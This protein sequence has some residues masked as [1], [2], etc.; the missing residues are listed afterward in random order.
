MKKKNKILMYKKECIFLIN[1]KFFLYRK[2]SQ[3][4]S[5][6]NTRFLKHREELLDKLLDNTKIKL[7]KYA[8]C[9]SDNYKKLIQQ[10]LIQSFI[11]MKEN[12][13][14]VKCRECDLDIVKEYLF[15]LK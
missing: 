7:A 13:L 6:Q 5:E 4:L 3:V 2:S 14:Q 10:L 11:K 15:N 8:D 9:K 1:S 12:N